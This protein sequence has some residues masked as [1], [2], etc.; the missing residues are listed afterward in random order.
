MSWPVLQRLLSVMPGVRRTTTSAQWEGSNAL[1]WIPEGVCP[2]RVFSPWHDEVQRIPAE[3]AVRAPV[4]WLILTDAAECPRRE[5]DLIVFLVGRFR[6]LHRRG[7]FAIIHIP[8]TYSDPD[9]KVIDGEIYG[10]FEWWESQIDYAAQLAGLEATVLW[11]EMV[12]F[13]VLRLRAENA[14]ECEALNDWRIGNYF[15]LVLRRGGSQHTPAKRKWWRFW[16]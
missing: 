7:G 6:M 3:V 14:E 12:Q 2:Q 11:H 5:E 10:P 13:E 15:L 1:P 8:V 16:K 9:P 4:D